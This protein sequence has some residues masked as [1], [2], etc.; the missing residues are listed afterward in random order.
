[1]ADHRNSYRGGSQFAVSLAEHWFL[2][3]MLILNQ[4]LDNAG[5]YE[6]LVLMVPWSVTMC[7]KP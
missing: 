2:G 6:K 1:M 5:I 3:E 7:G 4:P